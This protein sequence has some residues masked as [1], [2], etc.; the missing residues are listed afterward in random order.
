M[1]DKVYALL[2][3]NEVF[4]VIDTTGMPEQRLSKYIDGFSKNVTGKDITS[5]EGVGINSVFNGVYFENGEDVHGPEFDKNNYRTYC[6]M[7]DY[8]IFA[9]FG[10]E[11][12][13]E[14]AQRWENA[15]KSSVTG[16]DVTGLDVNNGDLF[17]GNSFIKKGGHAINGDSPWQQ[18]KKNL[19][20]T[21][22]WDLINP[23]EPKVS[24]E[25]AE[26][27]FNICKTC[28]FLIPLTSQCK[29]CGCMM[30][31]KTKLLKAECPEGKW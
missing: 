30:K 9:M 11:N 6:L 16:L 31:L 17:D 14:H 13:L 19:G 18:W 26:E 25:Q 4:S 21:R 20:E 29:K 24:K 12:S 2:V 28:P 7:S 1:Q 27:R 10:V 3:D 23:S 15:F 22:P 8:K 5:Y